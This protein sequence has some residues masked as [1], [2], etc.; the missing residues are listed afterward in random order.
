MS[1][2]C[3]R[4]SKHM[5]IKTFITYIDTHSSTL[6]LTHIHVYGVQ[7]I[8]STLLMNVYSF[9]HVWRM[10]Y[11]CVHIGKHMHT[12]TQANTCGIYTYI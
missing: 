10:S 6:I 9:A 12:Q 3:V 11:R 4:I 8:Y 1:Y 2:K 5:L 7:L